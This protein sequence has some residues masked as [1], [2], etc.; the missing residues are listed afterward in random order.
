MCSWRETSILP[1]TGLLML[2]TGVHEAG[3][4]SGSE[5][6]MPAFGPDT[7]VQ[8]FVWREATAA[9]HVCVEPKIRMFTRLQTADSGKFRSENGGPFGPDTCK[10]GFVWR[11]AVPDD[12]A[13]VAPPVRDFHRK[14]TE[15][16]SRRWAA[17][18]SPSG[19]IDLAPF[20]FP[21]RRTHIRST[22]SG[23]QNLVVQAPPGDAIFPDR[24]HA[25]VQPD[26]NKDSQ[27]FLF[28]RRG[29]G[30]SHQNAFQLMDLATRRCLGVVDA[31]TANGAA[32]TL[33]PCRWRNNATWYLQR[34]PDESWELRALHSDKCLDA[35]NPAT[36][37]PPAG[38]RVQ[39]WDCLGGQNQAWQVA[40]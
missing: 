10:S 24:A 9:D 28:V 15:Q 27:S 25:T 5:S 35:A 31:S 14:E 18:A 32:V 8:R 21:D 36:T 39:Q 34:R 26:V 23:H 33:R 4:A 22:F 3:A 2:T 30:I 16:V 20:L 7:C 11:E 29:N 17:T 19:R 40:G 1:I 13:C 38:A 37:A 12:H 6:A